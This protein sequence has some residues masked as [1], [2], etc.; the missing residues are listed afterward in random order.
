M[1]YLLMNKL[2]IAMWCIFKIGILMTM[3]D[4]PTHSVRTKIKPQ[5]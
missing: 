5:Y 3:Y 2:F 4:K 1:N